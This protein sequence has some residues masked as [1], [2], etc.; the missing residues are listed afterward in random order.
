MKKIG[1]GKKGIEPIIAT[2]L[3]IG[4]VVAVSGASFVWFKSMTKESV[5]KFEK[6]IEL[7]CADVVLSASYSSAGIQVSNT[8]NVPVKG[9]LVKLIGAGK[10]T[11]IDSKA[12]TPIN[13]GDSQTLTDIT[14]TGYTEAVVIPILLGQGETGQKTFECDEKNGFS[15]TL[16]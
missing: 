15:V 12:S 1:V 14:T 6:N 4:M 5:T 7:T 11:T 8:G 16:S 9:V 10:S 13:V 3:L 2:V